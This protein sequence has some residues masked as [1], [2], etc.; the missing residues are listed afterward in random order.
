MRTAYRTC[1][2]CEATCGLEVTLDG[3]RGRLRSAATPTTSSRSGFLC[4]KGVGLKALHEDPDRLR[5]PMV[6]D[7]DG[8]AAPGV[9]GRG[10][11][12]SSPSACRRSSSSTAATRSPCTSATRPRTTSRRCIYGRVLLKA[13]GT[14]NIFSAIDRRPVPQADGA[15]YMFGG[16]AVVPVPDLDR[17]AAPAHAR[18]EP[19]RV[20]R[21]A[22]DRARRARPAAGDP[23]ARRQGRRRRPAALAH[24]EG[25]R[26][27]RVDPARAPTRSRSWRSSTSCSPRA[28]ATPHE[29]RRRRRRRRARSRA[30]FTPEAVSGADRRSPPRR[31]GGWR[32]SSATRR[33]RRRLRADRHDDAA[34][35]HDRELARRRAQRDHRQPR[36]AGRRDVPAARARASA[37]TG[38]RPRRAVRPLDAAAC[39]SAPEIFGELPVACLAEEI[40]T[41]GEGQ[42][43][44]L[45][46]IAGNPVVSTPNAERLDARARRRST[47]WSALDIYVNETTRHADVILPGAV[48][49]GEV[50]LRR[51]RSTASRCATSPTT[52]APVLDDRRCRR[53][54]RRCCG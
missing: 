3:D 12:A 28:S 43:R 42:V 11:R 32:A 23:G 9:V 24:R 17:T 53:S 5:T 33:A 29:L 51:S 52:A 14:K 7:A 20:E 44:A 25:R 36:P 8:D 19:A 38:S 37:A 26:R 13:L 30:D 1:P 49:A 40:E 47:S 54:G 15:A 41:P 6:R 16:G 21:L 50:A 2:F 45:I 22:D 4:P 18:R 48:A 10:V 35:R 27:A 34:L 46:T 39:A 31:C